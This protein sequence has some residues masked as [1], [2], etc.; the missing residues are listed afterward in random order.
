LGLPLSRAKPD[1]I[2]MLD[3]ESRAH[4]FPFAMNHNSPWGLRLATAHMS[5]CQCED[6]LGEHVFV[7]RLA[8]HLSYLD[9]LSDLLC[10]A[11]G[12]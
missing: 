11:P 2:S 10:S 5:L 9:A 4:V 6:V 8:W 7:I 1:E 3:S 12:G